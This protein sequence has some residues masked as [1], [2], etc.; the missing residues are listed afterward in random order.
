VFN[1]GRGFGYDDGLY[2]G[3]RVLEYLSQHPDLS[4]SKA[5]KIYPER[6]CTEDTYIST[7]SE[8]PA[9]VLH[10]VELKSHDFGA[11][12]SKIDG[13]RLDFEDGFG[14][15][16]ASNT[17]EYFTVRFD[18][19]NPVRLNA[20]RDTFVSMLSDRYPKIAQDILDAQ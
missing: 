16:R 11:Q 3:L 9:A 10:D 12:L 1:D 13:I 5:L 7:H 20:I 4:L 14:I 19:D 18:A 17:G 2:A 6:Y 8:V 15:I